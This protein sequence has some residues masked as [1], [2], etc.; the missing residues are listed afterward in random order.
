MPKPTTL[1]AIGELE[2]DK[3][4]QDLPDNDIAIAISPAILKFSKYLQKVKSLG[5][6]AVPSQAA[7]QRQLISKSGHY[8]PIYLPPQ[9]AKSTSIDTEICSLEKF[10]F[11]R[12][13]EISECEANDLLFFIDDSL[14]LL[15]LVKMRYQV[16]L[17]V[18]T[19]YYY[20]GLIKTRIATDQANYSKIFTTYI[21]YFFD[22]AST[23]LARFLSNNPSIYMKELTK[24]LETTHILEN[25]LPDLPKQD[26]QEIKAKIHNWQNTIE[27]SVKQNSKLRQRRTFI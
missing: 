11:Q 24:F 25:Y 10:L 27:P 16:S 20:F 3:D 21:K 4:S 17:N 5:N 7:D 2:N 9:Q 8:K 13:A 26:H 15:S 23:L 12:L 22:T 6:L 19:D 18:K 1:E 14:K